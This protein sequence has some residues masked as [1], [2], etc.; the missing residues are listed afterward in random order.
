MIRG[1][2]T[3]LLVLVIFSGGCQTLKGKSW[4]P[5]ADTLYEHEEY[6]KAAELYTKII[7]ANRKKNG[8][9]RDRSVYNFVYKRAVCY[10]S[11]EEFGKALADVAI[12]EPQFPRMPQP[13]IL[14]AFIYRELDDRDKQLENLNAVMSLQAT[15]KADFLKWRG[16][17]EI[18]GKD[19]INAYNDL[20][21]A[22]SLEHDSEV[23]TYL[24]LYYHNTG[25]RDSTYLSFNK[26]IE[27]N[28]AHLSAYLYA[29]S[30]AM[31]A[32]EY[33]QALEYLDLGLRM[34]PKNPNLLFYRGVA[35][36]ETSRIDEGCRC[37]NRAFYNGVD[38]A[39]DYLQQ[40]CFGS[41]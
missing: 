6:A 31:E 29:G 10:Y 22:K 25:D 8:S 15:P 9:F 28:P 14:K 37:L 36:I 27:L 7:D 12:F 35:L 3:L 18:Q 17:L 24:G 40:Y 32:G 39:G 21:K 41:N 1:T 13:K 33:S 5:K 19:Y 30:V 38:D 26:A 23:E 4:I 2:L 16:L 20:L 34:D 11:T